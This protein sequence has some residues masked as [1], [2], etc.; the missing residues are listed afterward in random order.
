MEVVLKVLGGYNEGGGS[1]EGDGG[2]AESNRGY[3]EGGGGSG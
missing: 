3:A 1:A 2:C